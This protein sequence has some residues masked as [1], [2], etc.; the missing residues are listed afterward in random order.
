MAPILGSLYPGDAGWGDLLF[1][2]L[3][4]L[5]TLLLTASYVYRAFFRSR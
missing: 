1:A 2:G 4:S 5:G 3:W